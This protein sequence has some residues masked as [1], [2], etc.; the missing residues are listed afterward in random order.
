MKRVHRAIELAIPAR[1]NMRVPPPT[2][3]KAL[4]ADWRKR[5]ETVGAQ[6]VYCAGRLAEG[7]KGR[8]MYRLDQH[9]TE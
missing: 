1:R 5:I 7:R 9:G 3:I 2:Q 6:P 8:L 4:S